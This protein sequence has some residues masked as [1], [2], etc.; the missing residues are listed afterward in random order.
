MGQRSRSVARSSEQRLASSLIGPD[1]PGPFA[2]S[3][4]ATSAA[5][6]TGKS[7]IARFAERR[8]RFS[9]CLKSRGG[10][11]RALPRLS[12]VRPAIILTALLAF[13]GNLAKPR[14]AAAH[15]PGI[16][17]VG[18]N[19]APRPKVSFGKQIRAR[20]LER[21]PGRVAAMSS[22]TG[23]RSSGGRGSSFEPA[24]ADQGSGTGKGSVGVRMYRP[25]RTILQTNELTD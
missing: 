24:M 17:K 4:R 23:C 2:F 25:C 6:V 7:A 13:L 21:P 15:V 1:G 18:S 10:H 8:L 3:P 20:R 22:T 14:T 19:E 16:S 5:G 9:K 12:N 11:M